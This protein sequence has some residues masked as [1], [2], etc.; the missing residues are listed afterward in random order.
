TQAD[1]T[2]EIGIYTF[3][4]TARDP[5]T[6][7]QLGAGQRLR[8]L[9]EEIALADQVGLD[10]FGV[11]EHHRQGT[12]DRGQGTGDRGQGMIEEG[13]KKSRQRPHEV[14]LRGLQ[15]LV[16]TKP[17]CSR[18]ALVTAREAAA[19]EAS[20][21]PSPVLFGRGT[22]AKRQGEGPAGSRLPAPSAAGATS[23]PRLPLA[24]ASR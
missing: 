10:V 14:S 16:P 22:G 8:E 3:A 11:G 18:R 17:R 13:D 20:P 1:G 24:A 19:S 12:G 21:R 7:R 5:R 2:M 4:E 6:G 9:I 23:I 15:A